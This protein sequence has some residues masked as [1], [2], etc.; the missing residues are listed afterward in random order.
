MT[1]GGGAGTFFGDTWKSA[2]HASH[3][4]TDL[5][6]PGKLLRPNN[7]SSLQHSHNILKSCN[8][9]WI[10]LFRADLQRAL[11]TPNK[12][13]A[14]TI[15][16]TKEIV[17]QLFE[18][19]AVSNEKSAK[20][21]AGGH[22]VET[23]EMHVY[24]TMEKKYGL[25]SLAAE[26]TG[27]LLHAVQRFSSQDNTIMVFVKV[28]SNEIEEEFRDVQLELVRSIKDLLRVQLMSK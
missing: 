20:S 9:N 7:Q 4:L 13:R 21:G 12:C 14:M 24:R 6:S 11:D 18:T 8:D 25:R 2:K 5:Q 1:T 26:H 17:H 22:L 15:H 28:F 23:M 19:K 16:E 3:S 10:F 27:A